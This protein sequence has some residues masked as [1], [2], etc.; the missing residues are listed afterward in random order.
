MKAIAAAAWAVIVVTAAAQTPSSV[1]VFARAREATWAIALLR[2]ATNGQVEHAA[3]VGSG[4]FVS[5]THFV[6]AEHVINARLLGRTRNPRDRIRV[7]KNELQGD[8]FNAMKIIHEDSSLDIAILE[9]AIPT[10]AWLTVSTAEPGEGEPIGSY[11][12]PLVEF[13]NL[14]RSFAFPLG[15]NGMVAGYGRDNGVRRMITSFG[16]S[17]GNSGGPVFL[18]STGHAVAVTKAQMTDL[19][20]KD[21]D[22]YST[23]T[24]LSA[25]QSE[26]QRFGIGKS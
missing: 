14:S 17:V 16:S 15:R 22:G 26:L 10:S 4:F 21:L 25:V 13:G 3:F 7:F 1:D 8:G 19:A 18:L 24:P 12:Y 11:G 20:G 9:S 2:Y 5:R 6:T 23:S